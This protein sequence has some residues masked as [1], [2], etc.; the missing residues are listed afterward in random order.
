MSWVMTAEDEAAE[1][2]D[3]LGFNVELA[4]CGVVVGL[5][6]PPPSSGAGG[7]VKSGT[8]GTPPGGT[9]GTTTF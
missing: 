2:L 6:S 8:G 9:K 3:I 5:S 4:I 1:E 7:G